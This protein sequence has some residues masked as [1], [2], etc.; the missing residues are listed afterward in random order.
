MSINAIERQIADKAERDGEAQIKDDVRY[1]VEEEIHDKLSHGED[2]NEFFDQELLFDW[3][4][5]EP[6]Y[7]EAVIKAAQGK[8][9]ELQSIIDVT[10]NGIK[11]MNGKVIK[12]GLVDRFSDEVEKEIK[13]W[14]VQIAA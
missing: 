2:Y 11:D 7:R 6:G 4:A 10:I 13:N 1:K 14:I 3:A 8:P 9:S 5:D 12:Q